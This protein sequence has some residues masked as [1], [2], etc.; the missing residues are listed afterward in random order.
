MLSLP[1]G[2]G[3]EL[4][5]L[6][7]WQAAE[8]AAYV[9][10]HIDHLGPWL[11]W[12]RAM[13]GE[14]E[15]RA[16]LQPY[17]DDTARDG[18]RMYSVWLDGELVGGTLFRVFDAPAGTCE[19]GVWLAPEATGRG[20]VS[21][22]VTAMIDWAVDVRGI[23]RVEWQCVPENAASR[24]VA[25]R[26]GMTLEGTRRRAFEHDGRLWDVELWALLAEE[27]RARRTA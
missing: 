9:G 24:A 19:L 27:W 16:F 7:P 23:R 11:P 1:L 15:A 17:A 25:T 6:E 18:R 20:L 4:R 3:A 8:F 12:S 26:L 2:D 21:R 13:T 10:R 5:P 22:A 14:A